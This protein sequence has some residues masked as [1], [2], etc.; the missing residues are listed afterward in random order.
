MICKTL[1]DFQFVLP[2][3]TSTWEERGQTI[4]EILISTGAKN[5]FDGALLMNDRFVSLNL[6]LLG[7]LRRLI[8][9]IGAETSTRIE[10]KDQKVAFLSTT[11]ISI[12]D[13]L[14][15]RTD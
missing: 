6:L 4:A 7:E 1:E 11:M 9:S 5:L 3:P 10:L 12:S 2:H 13:Q 14:R 15:R 8:D